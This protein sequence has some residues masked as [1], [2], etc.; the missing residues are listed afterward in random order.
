MRK[1]KTNET[2]SCVRNTLS[3]FAHMRKKLRGAR[4]REMNAA[5]RDC[6]ISL[7]MV[8]SHRLE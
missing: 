4:L 7:D 1:D 3:N 5:L 6:L 8:A 2:P